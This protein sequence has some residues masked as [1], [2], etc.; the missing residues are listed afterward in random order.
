M[1]VCDERM[2]VMYLCMYVCM[3][4]L[5]GSDAGAYLPAELARIYL[6][7][8]RSAGLEGHMCVVFRLVR[9]EVQALHRDPLDD[10]VRVAHDLGPLATRTLDSSRVDS[11]SVGAHVHRCHFDP[12][13]GCNPHYA[14]LN[15]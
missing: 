4:P 7:S 11:H 2:Y 3:Q 5:L 9:S 13:H 14:V 1:Y 6:A 8:L 12:F 15:P 10:L